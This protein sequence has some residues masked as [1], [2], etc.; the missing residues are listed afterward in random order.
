MMVREVGREIQTIDLP[1]LGEVSTGTREETV[2]KG[3]TSLWHFLPFFIK[4]ASTYKKQS[5]KL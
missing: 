1:D 4:R 5:L 3:K 2:R